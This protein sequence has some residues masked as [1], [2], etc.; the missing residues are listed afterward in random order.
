M[1]HPKTENKPFDV[2]ILL[3][4]GIGNQ[5]S[6]DL[7]KWTRP[8]VDEI[9]SVAS[10]QGWCCEETDSGF[11]RTVYL[12]KGSDRRTISFQECI[13]SDAFSRPAVKEMIWWTLSRLP[14][15]PLFLLTPDSEDLER[16]TSEKRPLGPVVRFA[17]RF[18]LLTGAV[19]LASTLILYTFLC[20]RFIGIIPSALIISLIVALSWTFREKLEIFHRKYNLIG[21][22]RVAA[23]QTVGQASEISTRIDEAVSRICSYSNSVTVLAHSQGGFLAH[24]Q[25]SKSRHR[26]NISRLIGVGSGLRPISVL[27][28]CENRKKIFA[29]WILLFLNS[30]NVPASFYALSF[31][32]QY[33]KYILSQFR[34]FTP[35]ILTMLIPV[36]SRGSIIIS[37]L[38]F[39]HLDIRSLAYILFI[40]PLLFVFTMIIC[41][42]SAVIINKTFTSKVEEIPKLE[43]VE[44]STSHDIVGRIPFPNLPDRVVS[45]PVGSE[46]N[47][48]FD[49][50]NYFAQD[51]LTP[52][53]VGT[54]LARDVGLEVKQS[55][56]DYKILGARLNLILAKR[57]RLMT[58]IAFI[59]SS[60]F[61]VKFFLNPV[62][63]YA[64]LF[65]VALFVSNFIIRPTQYLMNGILRKHDVETA[66][67]S[68]LISDKTGFLDSRAGMFTTVTLIFLG[69]SELWFFYEWIM[70]VNQGLVEDSFTPCILGPAVVIHLGWI[71]LL[72]SG[73]N[74]DGAKVC[75]VVNSLLVIPLLSLFF[76]PVYKVTLPGVSNIPLNYPFGLFPCILS[77]LSFGLT[78]VCSLLAR[79]RGR[80]IPGTKNSSEGSR[81]DTII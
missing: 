1:K 67:S 14:L 23:S 3:I 54:C 42:I 10:G 4:H 17:V 40:P 75:L 5:K 27:S 60:Y 55:L 81:Y 72:C 6:G 38:P 58:I 46:G 45:L 57:W 20:F 63:L 66:S 78:L 32:S 33:L 21:H 37:Q 24:K 11:D 77:M 52:K 15:A 19:T 80:K 25:L 79:R 39:T 2:S 35:Y 44:I 34:N 59:F 53:I 8:I 73:Y 22:V 31:F 51:M 76:C 71:A 30:I 43:W 9:R 56:T 28:A 7:L 41:V 70:V 64:I 16:I 50:L 65:P 49:H 69:L 68:I 62:S 74:V 48:L 29:I 18:L 47:P 26:R 61:L 13:W 36:D 12:T